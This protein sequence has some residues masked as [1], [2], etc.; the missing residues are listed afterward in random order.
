MSGFRKNS[1]H[2]QGCLA[3]EGDPDDAAAYNTILNWLESATNSGFL[4]PSE[5]FSNRLKGNLGEFIAYQLGKNY[6]FTNIEIAPS[7]N[8]WDPLFQM[9]KPDIDIVWLY[10]GDAETEDWAAIQE[11]KTTG[12][13]SLNLAYDLITDYD[14]LFGENPRLTLQARFAALKNKLEEFG[15]AEL[16]PRLTALGGF[17][18]NTA[19][20]IRIYPTLLH[21]SANDSSAKMVSVRQT[22]IGRG[23]FPSVVE[24]WSISLS[25]LDNRL[26]R[27][28]R[29]QL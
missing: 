29:G 24:C 17:S 9:S 12:E 19:H 6:V 8:A 16:S 7:A 14:K 13:A 5:S 27:L 18:P 10:F 15:Q 28:A 20:G 21:D 22:L 4:K 11:V 25:D 2:I 3:W 23:W 26:S 1:N